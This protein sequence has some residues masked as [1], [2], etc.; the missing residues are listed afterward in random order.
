M[1]EHVG[2]AELPVDGQDA[3]ERAT[4]VILGGDAARRW[5][6]AVRAAAQ[7]FEVAGGERATQRDA[8]VLARQGDRFGGHGGRVREIE[9]AGRG[10]ARDLWT[11]AALGLAVAARI[12]GE[13]D[14]A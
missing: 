2:G 13:L 5:R 11:A 9:P 14:I 8:V 4:P 6:R 1:A 10:S 12:R 7:A 3:V